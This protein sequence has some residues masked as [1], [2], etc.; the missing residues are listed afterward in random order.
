N[1]MPKSPSAPIG[2]KI[3]SGGQTGA[4]RA[5]L[6]VALRLGV[7]CG[8]WCPADRAAEDGAVPEHYPV[9]PLPAGGYAQRT[10]R[11]VLESDGTVVL[12][13]GE[14]DGGTKATIVYCN[15][16][17]RPCLVIDAEKT[18]VEEAARQLADFVVMQ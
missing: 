10:E 11:N 6:D 4:D 2:L 1:P 5:A 17:R 8:G 13:Y 12:S 15:Q 7:P 3:I 18:T 9:T 14:P 16:H